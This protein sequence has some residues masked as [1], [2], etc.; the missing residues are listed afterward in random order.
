MSKHNKQ[1]KNQ[2]QNQNR[3]ATTDKDLQRKA[4]A[5]G[6]KGSSMPSK[7]SNV[8]DDQIGNVATNKG[9]QASG[10]FQ[11]QQE[12]EEADR[13][14]NRTQQGRWDADK[15]L[16]GSDKNQANRNFSA[17]GK[18]FPSKEKDRNAN[19]NESSKR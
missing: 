9:Y 3:Q 1:S 19:K 11:G 4:G 6:A 8:D 12:D 2:N 7:E 18:D 15:T 13:S 10:R 17:S 5:T 14:G 16:S